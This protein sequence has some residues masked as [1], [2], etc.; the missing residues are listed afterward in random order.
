[1]ISHNFNVLLIGPTAITVQEKM[2][3]FHTGIVKILEKD[4]G[5]SSKLHRMRLIEFI[6]GSE[7]VHTV[8]SKQ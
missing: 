5:V 6:E 1:M 8:I 7:C 3:G 2:K 4:L